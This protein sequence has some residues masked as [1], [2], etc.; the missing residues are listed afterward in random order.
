MKPP[1][2]P[3][4][5]PV[6]HGGG[7]YSFEPSWVRAARRIWNGPAIRSSDIGFR[8]TLTVRSPRV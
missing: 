5:L 3:A 2:K 1:T 8:T 4:D 7:W 6:I